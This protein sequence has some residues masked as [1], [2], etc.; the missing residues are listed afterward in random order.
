MRQRD[1]ETLRHI[2]YEAGYSREMEGYWVSNENANPY[3][4]YAIYIEEGNMVR[5]EGE[6]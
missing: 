2:G 5:S 4:G 3:D 6:K 1:F